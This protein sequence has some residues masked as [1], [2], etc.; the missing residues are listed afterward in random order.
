[1]FVK[2]LDNERLFVY[3][4]NRISRNTVRVYMITQEN[5]FVN[6]LLKFLIFGEKQ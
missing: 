5:S 4:V 3:N 2:T 6:R 1:M